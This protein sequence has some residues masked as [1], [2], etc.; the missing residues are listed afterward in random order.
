VKNADRISAAVI[1]GICLYFWIEAREFSPL[2]GFFP[3][4]IIVL[5]AALAALLLVFSFIRPREGRV[6]TGMKSSFLP[7][8]LVVVL[9]IAWTFL[10]QVFG[11][12][13]TSVVFF[14][15]LTVLL[16]RNQRRPLA[17][18]KRIAMVIALTVCLYLF[19]DRLLLVSFPR[20]LLI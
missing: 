1:L 19:F 3:Q 4:V 9:L 8:L 2:S 7:V 5:L 17:V 12:L 11:F 16:D 20:G 13:V 6:F 10:I 18:L 14:T 15:L